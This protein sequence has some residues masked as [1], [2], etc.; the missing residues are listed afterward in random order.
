MAALLRVCLTHG[1]LAW[2]SQYDPHVPQKSPWFEG[3]YTRISETSSGQSIGLIIG[4]Y[5]KTD[6]L[7]D[8]AAY[9]ALIIDEG[10]GK[11]DVAEVNPT[12]LKVG[13]EVS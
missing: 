13:L 1:L 9:L 10:K 2:A 8:A 5:P 12:A 4:H 3:W 11:V 7:K 6:R